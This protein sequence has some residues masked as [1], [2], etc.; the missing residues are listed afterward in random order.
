[1]LGSARARADDPELTTP[2]P[3]DY[4]DLMQAHRYGEVAAGCEAELRE[5]P[6]DE[7]LQGWHAHAMLC[8]GRL[9]EALE[10]YRGIA[11]RTSIPGVVVGDRDRL[12]IG[13]IEWMLG[14]PREALATFRH[15]ADGIVDGS[16]THSDLAGGVG[17]GVLL[18]YAAVSVGDDETKRH[19]IEYLRGR[20]RR[21]VAAYWP[22]P[23]ARYAL[24]EASEE[25]VL[26][27]ACRA[28][29]VE[30]ATR[31]A[32]IPLCPSTHLLHFEPRGSTGPAALPLR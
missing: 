9:P 3:V 20:A 30:R 2:Q 31:V 11:T 32:P 6:R 18:W 1:M 17:P 23:L 13:A 14:R 10:E 27:A 12:T 7:A 16:I 24:G 26:K 29:D 19:A 5:N 22:G 28:G 15:T 8:L 21:K 25:D 4:G